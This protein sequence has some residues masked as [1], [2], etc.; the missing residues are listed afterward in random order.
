MN[1]QYV[2][3]VENIQWVQLHLLSSGLLHVKGTCF[4]FTGFCQSLR[5][6][7][8]VALFGLSAL[9]GLDFSLLVLCFFCPP[10]L[11]LDWFLFLFLFLC[12]GLSSLSSRVSGTLGLVRVYIL[13]YL[14]FLPEV[15]LF[16]TSGVFHLECQLQKC[17]FVV[18]QSSILN[19]KKFNLNIRI[20]S[21]F[22]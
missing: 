6:L 2:W 13:S 22:I 19:S 18:R 10:V 20:S 12:S 4:Y 1:N 11:H 14:T 8:V 7:I 3:K 9:L 21:L 17:V 5:I 16:C 15:Y